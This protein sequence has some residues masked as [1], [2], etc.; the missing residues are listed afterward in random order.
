MASWSDAGLQENSVSGSHAAGIRCQLFRLGEPR[1]LIFDVNADHEGRIIESV[2]IDD[3]NRGAEFELVLHGTDY[4][5]SRGLASK[6]PLRRVVLRFTMDDGNARYH[7]PV[8]LAPHSYST[9]WSG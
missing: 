9:W 1:Q 5:A 8:M 7:L 3:A 6:S 4:F 2:E